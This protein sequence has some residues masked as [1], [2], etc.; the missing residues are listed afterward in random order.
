MSLASDMSMYYRNTYIGYRTNGGRVLP[1]FIQEV[2][3]RNSD[4]DYS[5]ESM[6][7]LVFSGIVY[8]DDREQ[9]KNISF[10]SGRLVLDLPELG[11]IVLNGRP[12]WLTYRPVQQASKG[13]SGR[14]VVGVGMNASVAKLI[15]K[16]VQDQP[17]NLARQFCFHNGKVLYKGLEQGTR[18]GDNVVL[19]H[20]SRFY[21]PY[22]LKAYPDL[23]VTIGEEE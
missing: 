10:N 3:G 8:Y 1:F 17:D 7:E 12:R 22:L 13:L 20:S 14:R 23:N 11:Y 16:A 4:S 19:K 2:N 18:D 21:A 6:D 5:Q 9:N 15:Y